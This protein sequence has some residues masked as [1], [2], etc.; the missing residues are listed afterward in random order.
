MSATYLQHFF[1]DASIT[2][3]Q[4][5]APCH[6]IKKTNTCRPLDQRRSATDPAEIATMAY[7]RNRRCKKR[8]KPECRWQSAPL[9]KTSDMDLPP[10]LTRRFEGPILSLNSLQTNSL[11]LQPR[12][13]DSPPVMKRSTEKPTITLDKILNNIDQLE[14]LDSVFSDDEI[15]L[16]PLGNESTHSV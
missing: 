7:N 5:N 13:G 6:L 9:K 11:F 1:K 3:I 8:S 16:E 2:V 12:R 10:V 15:L 4:D 14:N